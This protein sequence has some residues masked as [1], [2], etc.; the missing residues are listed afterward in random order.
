MA[1]C[2]RCHHDNP[3]AR[4]YCARCG[5]YLRWELTGPQGFNEAGG[6]AVQLAV[7]TGTIAVALGVPGIRGGPDD[8]VELA[9][10]AG[11]ELAVVARI[12]NEG[13]TAQRFAVSVEGLPESW[14]S[15]EPRALH[16]PSGESEVE[17][18]LH[19]PRSALAEARRW[20][21]WVEVT[22][23]DGSA[24]GRS[25]IA[26]LTLDTY[27]GC[28]ATLE[29]R[30]R[31]GRGATH[32]TVRLRNYGNTPTTVGLQARDDGGEC[33]C[34]CDV[35]RLALRPG[36]DADVRVTVRPPRRIVFGRPVDRDIRID[37]TTDQAD[38]LPELVGTYRQRPLLSRWLLAVVPIVLA[39]VLL[40]APR[41]SDVTV[42]SLAGLPGTAPGP[43]PA[44]RRRT[45]ARTARQ[46]PR[47]P[48]RR[49]R[50]GR[51]SEPRS[52]ST[53]GRGRR[54]EHRRRRPDAQA[55]VHDAVGQGRLKARRNRPA[56]RHP[57]AFPVLR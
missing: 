42:P 54:G 41:G 17:V 44:R 28:V 53:R 11:G 14:W 22:P 33:G 55:S 43:A 38:A 30:R 40:V 10:A 48:G 46:A 6:R 13:A 49:A 20:A 45:P 29:P 26:G 56:I 3:A 36:E 25:A 47:R 51:R 1:V 7:P 27:H 57:D 52:G 2:E 35:Q 16:L 32:F 37:A 12:R 50:H 8:P 21:F 23:D 4:E 18:R 31:A 39:L 34:R 15:V 24:G 19:P 9:L 5:W